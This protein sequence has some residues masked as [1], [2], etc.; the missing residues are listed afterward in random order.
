[1]KENDDLSK[2]KLYSISSNNMRNNQKL[3]SK[4]KSNDNNSNK[5]IEKE[6]SDINFIV[7]S[8]VEKINDLFNL[9]EFNKNNLSNSLKKKNH[10]KLNDLFEKEKSKT[11][12]G[13]TMK[14]NFTLNI[15]NFINVPSG[16]NS[17]LNKKLDKYSDED[18]N[19]NIAFIIQKNT[20]TKTNK[21][22]NVNNRNKN[23]LYGK[24]LK[25][26]I[27]K[28][29]LFHEEFGNN[30][31]IIPNE[32]PNIINDIST[33]NTKKDILKIKKKDNERSIVV[34]TKLK[35]VNPNFLNEN[36][37]NHKDIDNK[38]NNYNNILNFGNNNNNYQSLSNTNLKKNN[39]NKKYIQNNNTKNI[40]EA[41]I[42]VAT[43]KLLHQKSNNN[44][45]ISKRSKEEFEMRQNKYS[46][47]KI[48]QNNKKINKSSKKEINTRKIILID[49]N[50]KLESEHNTKN[51]SN[52]YLENKQL[53]NEKDKN[54][55][56]DINIK[57]Q[58]S[59]SKKIFSNTVPINSLN[60]KII[61]NN[62]KKN[63]NENNSIDT[64]IEYNYT[65]N[66]INK[67]NIINDQNNNTISNNN[68]RFNN[69]QN[70]NYCI[71][72]IKE[73]QKQPYSKSAKK[74]FHSHEKFQ[75]LNTH[76]ILNK[77]YSNEFPAKINTNEISKL[78]LFLNE[79]LINNNLLNDYYDVNNRNILDEYSNFFSDK[80]NIDYP[81]EKD[82]FFD[83]VVNCTKIIQRMWRKRKIKKHLELSDKN[84]DEELKK[85]VVNKYI[86]KSGYKI[87]KILGL[88]NSLVEEFHDLDNDEEINEMFYQIQNIIKKKLT[89]YEKNAL[90]KEYINTIIY[91]K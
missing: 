26:N 46:S 32:K 68:I 19:D 50:D 31:Q 64:N 4:N 66:G 71:K 33:N 70:M 58:K 6:C 34:N 56:E 5:L 84:E 9:K 87:K 43:Q 10:Q 53:I 80:I 61:E 54:S 82:V 69:Y 38:I 47:I 17:A 23:N 44:Y 27:S 79:Y 90:Y 7:K 21:S 18:E 65:N 81:K 3:T 14:P 11:I 12:K 39:I 62:N 60:N 73:V 22:N 57:N 25:E 72:N 48:K 41:K 35:K 16:E 2:I 29:K 37:D 40:K 24:N 75:R 49:K 77:I 74:T 13:T 8:S 42:T 63:I 88:F 89:T 91:S 86:K 51:N 28:K 45:Q 15:N 78:M 1:M 67:I 20:K 36:H 30:I 83:K 52:L 55:I 76:K 59:I 85:M